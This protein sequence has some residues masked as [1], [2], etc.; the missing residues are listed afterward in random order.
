MPL[1]LAFETGSEVW[2]VALLRG[3]E[4]LATAA[5]PARRPQSERLLPAVEDVLR[6]AGCRFEQVDAL[7]LGIGPGSFTGL[8]VGLATVKGLAF[9]R[10]RPV[11]AVPTLAALAR[12]AGQTELPVIALLDASRQEVYAAAYGAGGEHPLELLPEGLYRI[13]ELAARLPAPC[14]AVGEPLLVERLRA[15][16]AEIRA[17]G[18]SLPGAAHVGVLAARALARGEA[19]ATANDLVP[20]YVRRAEAEARRLGRPVEVAGGHE[21]A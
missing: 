5:E 1:I 11:F 17:G 15:A 7:A 18:S 9:G 20:R 4:S 21:G 19:G 16:G 10:A 3:E 13:P 2:S 12:A 14:V 6:R 8:R